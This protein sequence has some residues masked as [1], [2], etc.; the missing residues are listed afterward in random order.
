MCIE[1]KE[2][3]CVGSGSEMLI[4]CFAYDQVIEG[5]TWDLFAKSDPFDIWS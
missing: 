4:I 1:F 2:S 5:L 3:Q